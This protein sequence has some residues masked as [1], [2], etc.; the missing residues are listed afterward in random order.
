MM[1][2]DIGLAW[3]EYRLKVVPLD[4]PVHQVVETRRA[5]FAGAAALVKMTT[6]AGGMSPHTARA[7]GGFQRECERFQAE[8]AS[9]RA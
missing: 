2:N 3:E 5:F 9:G 8:V 7:L 6:R 4:A 1:D